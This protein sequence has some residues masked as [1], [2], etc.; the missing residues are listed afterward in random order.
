MRKKPILRKTRLR[1]ESSK[2][3]LQRLEYAKLRKEFMYP[4]R[5]CYCC[6]LKATDIHH[7]AGRRGTTL[8]NTF[9]WLAVCR[10]CHRWIH[11]NPSEAREKGLLV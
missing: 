5:G 7:V 11:E 10:S 6:G 1:S 8:N 9:M 3:R 4:G 2:R